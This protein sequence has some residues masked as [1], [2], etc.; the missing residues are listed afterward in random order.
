MDEYNIRVKGTRTMDPDS[1]VALHLQFKIG[2][3]PSESFS[4]FKGLDE[5]I[6]CYSSSP[7][8]SFMRGGL[9]PVYYEAKTGRVIDFKQVYSVVPNMAK[10][11]TSS[12]GTACNEISMGTSLST[13]VFASSISYPDG[14]IHQIF[15]DVTTLQ[16]A[17]GGYTYSLPRPSRV[18]SNRGFEM[19]FT[20]FSNVLQSS[21]TD[22]GTAWL[23]P[24][25]VS[26]FARGNSVPLATVQLTQCCTSNGEQSIT[27]MAGNIWT[28]NFENIFGG[29]GSISSGR[30]VKPTSTVP[31]MTASST[32]KEY[33]YPPQ[34][35]GSLLT[36]LVVGDQSWT[37]A[38][39]HSVPLTT[40][41]T[42]NNASP[43]K[44]RTVTIN[45]PGGYHRVVTIDERK[46]DGGRITQDVDSL[47]RITSFVYVDD[48]AR[49]LSE[50]VYPEGNREVFTYDGL[51]NVLTHQQVPKPG[52]GLAP[53]TI[54][55][56]YP[57]ISGCQGSNAAQGT[58]AVPRSIS[59]YR[60][61]WVK[62]A[63]GNQTDYVWDQV[64]G[65]I[66]KKTDPA[67]PD[68]I[69][70]ETRYSYTQRFAWWSD[71]NGGYTKADTPIWVRTSESRCQASAATGNPA[72]PCAGN[73][74]IL[75][76]LDY[77]PDA[78][79]NYLLVRGVAVTSGGQTLRTCYSYDARG[80]KLSETRP[81]GTGGTCP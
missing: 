7:S 37:Y 20:Y 76:T 33:R 53:L 66:L 78:G 58:A 22:N 28:G 75:T 61:L 9:A 44:V 4:C 63:K 46:W 6:G 52:S 12:S 43:T 74:E 26:I 64:T 38:Y 40:A 67:G 59:C 50:V 51:G 29:T 19:R 31:V 42:A 49:R 24:S 48:M 8:P 41:A 23:T 21:P 27:D 16:A 14:E 34:G 47:N 13:I 3:G 80:N 39:S 73:D 60:P 57:P 11:T 72:A 55:A 5:P 2:A 45:G 15:Y 77:G 65:M 62:D 56:A 79:P 71:G 18:V 1:G 25:S 36:N 32:A 70:P 54:Q 68:G 30:L 17:N 10:C 35:D 69:R 81:L